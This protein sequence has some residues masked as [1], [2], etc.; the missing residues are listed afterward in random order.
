MFHLQEQLL[1]VSNTVAD[2]TFW[3]PLHC[4]SY[5]HMTVT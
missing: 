1:F 3:P 5:L 4:N 2:I